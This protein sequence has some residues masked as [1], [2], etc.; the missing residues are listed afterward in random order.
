MTVTMTATSFKRFGF[1]ALVVASLAACTT[2][3][4]EPQG[5][6]RAEKAIAV[7]I[8]LRRWGIEEPGSGS[9]P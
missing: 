3:T 8:C 7:T 6:E 5:P 1:S 4:P 2:L 9:L